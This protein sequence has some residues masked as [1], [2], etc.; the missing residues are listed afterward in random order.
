L[1]NA[2][3]DV[4]ILGVF[5]PDPSIRFERFFRAAQRFKRAAQ[6]IEN[7]YGFLRRPL[8]LQRVS[9]RGD[10]ILMPCRGFVTEADLGIRFERIDSARRRLF[11]FFDG[12]GEES[13]LLQ[14]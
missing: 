1:P 11:K 8:A 6:H 13:G 12:L 4:P 3:R 5:P 7:L 10:G 14:R 9:K 2:L